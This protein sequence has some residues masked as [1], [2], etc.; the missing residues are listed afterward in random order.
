[1]ESITFQGVLSANPAL[2]VADGVLGIKPY[3]TKYEDNTPSLME[4]LEQ[5]NYIEDKIFSIYL[6]PNTVQA[7]SQIR[8]GGYNT[9]LIDTTSPNVYGE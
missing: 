8:F 7:S 9:E 1:M 5:N 3:S 6:S 4:Y 2:Q